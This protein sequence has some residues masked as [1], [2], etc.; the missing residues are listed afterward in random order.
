VLRPLYTV[1]FPEVAE[2][3]ARF[4]DVFR[5]ENSAAHGLSIRAHFT[6]VFACSAFNEG[7]YVA[8]VAAVAARTGPIHFD[9]RYAMLGADH[10][11]DRAYVFLVPDEG[12]GAISR[13]HDRLYGGP[14]AP[15]LRLDRPYIPHITIGVTRDRRRAK[16][17]CDEL[18]R[19]GIHIAGG[20]GALTVGAVNDGVF[21]ALSV[22]ELN[23][24]ES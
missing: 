12:Y 2:H 10:E 21:E 20:I 24:V 13:L 17:L 1:A 22:H 7:D 4:L 11:D 16:E 23:F 15:H 5:D 8:H 3:D 19:S 14:L 6:L 9:C 18:N